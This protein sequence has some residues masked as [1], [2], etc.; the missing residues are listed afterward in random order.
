MAWLPKLETVSKVTKAGGTAGGWLGI[1]LGVVMAFEGFFGY[2]YRD[3]VGVP[4]YC[5]GETENVPPKGTTFSETACREMLAK[6]L[7]RYDA[8]VG[9]CVRNWEA[10]PAARRA[11]IDSLAYNVGTGAVCKSTLVRKLNAGDIRGACAEFDRWNRAGGR[12][13]PGLVRRRAVERKMCEL[14]L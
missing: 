8:E 9:R 12:V 6:K 10:V 2:V 7:P 11:A 14:G 4:T 1:C 13:L 5:Y 3:P